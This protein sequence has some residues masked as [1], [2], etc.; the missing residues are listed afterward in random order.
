MFKKMFNTGVRHRLAE[1]MNQRCQQTTAHTS[2]STGSSSTGASKKGVHFQQGGDGDIL[3]F[4]EEEEFKDPSDYAYRTEKLEEYGIKDEPLR[5][6]NQRPPLTSASASQPQG[7]DSP[8]LGVTDDGSQSRAIKFKNT[9]KDWTLPKPQ[10]PIEHRGPKGIGEAAI[11]FMEHVKN[12]KVS[13]DPLRTSADDLV[14]KA[15]NQILR[16]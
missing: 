6:C 14:M 1:K 15:D 4:G 13:A 8:W 7:S 11:K 16:R 2:I 3:I 12:E 10:V 9:L 5:N